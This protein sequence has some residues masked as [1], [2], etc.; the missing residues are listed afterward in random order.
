MDCGLWNKN[1][2]C[3]GEWKDNFTGLEATNSNPTIFFQW[4]YASK[5]WNWSWGNS[6]GVKVLV[7]HVADLIPQVPTQAKWGNGGLQHPWVVLIT[8]Q[9]GWLRMVPPS[10]GPHIEP[11]IARRNPTL[12]KHHLEALPKTIWNKKEVEPK[13]IHTHCLAGGWPGFKP[14]HHNNSPHWQEE[15]LS[16]DPGEVTNYCWV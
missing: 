8:I 6:T 4:K 16:T 2:G 7:L 5:L 12:P 1:K 11:R 15:S 9:D 13:E 10:P 14:Q 3:Q